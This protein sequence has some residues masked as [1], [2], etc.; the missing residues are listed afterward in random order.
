MRKE[1]YIFIAVVALSAAYGIYSTTNML[2]GNRTPYTISCDGILLDSNKV[3][4]ISNYDRISADTVY[5]HFE[6]S[7]VIAPSTLGY[8]YF[9]RERGEFVLKN[10]PCVFNPTNGVPGNYFLP[11]CRTLHDGMLQDG[12]YFGGNDIISERVLLE[13]GIKYNTAVGT[14]ENRIS[15]EFSK[16]K[17]GMV[18]STKDEGIQTKYLVQRGSEN[19][20]EVYLNRPIGN[21]TCPNIFQFTHT[22]G[23]TGIYTIAATPSLFSTA[24]KVIDSDKRTIATG[25]GHYP[26]FFV[27][28]FQ[29][30]LKPKYSQF[31][32]AIFSACFILIFCFQIFLLFKLAK[33]K[34]PL[35]QSLFSF[36]IL[37]NCI[38]FMAIPLFLTSSYLVEGRNWYLLL[39]TLLN[40]SVF[41]PKDLFSNTKV[42]FSSKL[43]TYGSL[44]I[45]TVAP[46]VFK[47]GTVNENLFGILPVL[48]GQ[49][50][51]ILLLFFATQVSFFAA[52]KGRYFLRIAIIM[53]YSLMISVLTSDTGSFIYAGLAIVLVELIRKSIGLKHVFVSLSAIAVIVFLMF[54]ISPETFSKDRKTYRIVAPY[55]SPESDKLEMANQ[56]DRESYSSLNLNMQNIEDLVAPG[57]NDLIIPGNMRS[58]MHSDFAFHWSLT[59]GGWVFFFLFLTIIFLMLSKLLLLLYCSI[60]VCRVQ[61]EKG[62]IFPTSRSAE[63]VR[64]LLAFTI[65]GFTYPIAS[66]MLLIPL[67]GQSIPVLSI[68]NVEVIFLIVL[69]VS[70]ENIFNNPNH[71]VNTG[72]KYGYGDLRK[73]ILYGIS[74]IVLLFTSSLVWRFADFYFAPETLSWQKHISDERLKLQG[75]IPDM[76]DKQ[77][78]V[79]FAKEIIGSDDLTAVHKSKKPILKNLASLYY[80]NKPYTETI[81]EAATFS[82]STEKMRNQMSVDSFFSEKRVLISGTFEPYGKVF[83]MQQKV[84]NRLQH[85]VS[86]KFY[87]CIS[88]DATSINTDLT[89]ECNDTL[90]RH[91]SRIGF[92]EN[93]GSIVIV[94]NRTGGIVA[95][96][97]FPLDAEVN[98]NEVYYFIGSLKKT[99]LAYC[100]LGID[101]NYKLKQ[102]GNITFEEFL[103]TSDDYYAAALL[104]DLLTYH[105]EEFDEILQNDFGLPLFSLTDDSYLDVMPTPHDFSKPLD[106]NNT[107]YRQAI[108]QQRPYKF[109]DAVEWYARIASMTKLRLNFSDEHKKYDDLSIPLA[110]YEFLKNSLNSVL[111]GTASA[112]GATLRQNS[113]DTKTFLCKTGTAEKGNR[114]GNASSSFIIA[115]ERYTVGLMLSGTIPQNREKL[116]AKDL[117]NNLIPLLTKYEI[118][119][120]TTD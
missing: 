119:R 78:L 115:N 73:S 38:A 64:F 9:D 28:E 95:N 29:F 93:I 91:L 5:L 72:K 102:Y 1:L 69:L 26:T 112:V 68:S 98:S 15:L 81:H 111:T 77:A 84:N 23:D 83:S 46:F 76:N 47:L 25:E 4:A 7:K 66:N 116:A 41:L 62:F 6:Q 92:S 16:T 2:L 27:N 86:H 21:S 24:Y 79:D 75:Q 100:A 87:G 74:V 3:Y 12:I 108:G 56:A 109:I 90:E 99:I 45:L 52:T 54:K 49:K 58:T 120:P 97:S 114:S 13:R 43:I 34:S 89:A 103:K 101:E 67:T 61:Q 10:H 20:F 71:Y 22:A 32:G 51:L 94:D 17:Q 39:L 88:L 80:A 59:F 117:F 106:R 57:F 110:E 53:C 63:L 50:A 104:K 105:Q 48:H 36:R 85:N 18:L 35:I 11:F 44:L 113:I 42:N 70:L 19:V 107:I 96:S 30:S 118:L 40:L 55:V 82:N 14:K 8:V 33:A 37:L 31:F 65:I 60:R